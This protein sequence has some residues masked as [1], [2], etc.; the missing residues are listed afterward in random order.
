MKN[1]YF[2]SCSFG[3]DSTATAILAIEKGE[4][5][6][7]LVYC[8]IMFDKEKSAE[9]PEHRDFIYNT[10][11]PY[12]EQRGVKTIVLRA[13]KT[14]RE[15]MEA[16]VTKGPRKGKKHGFPLSGKKGWCSIKR[17]C[18]LPP[19][20]KFQK[21]HPGAVYYEGICIDEKSRIKE[22]KLAQGRYLLVK[23]GYTQEMARNLCKVPSNGGPLCASMT[24]CIQAK[25]LTS[26]RK[27]CTCRRTQY[28]AGPDMTIYR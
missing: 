17:D 11:I 4:P 22:E 24:G 6:S 1:E 28:A 26:R 7:A 16:R 25:S 21:E 15:W 18:K 2:V 19:L 13:E 10:A 8:E 5:L 12:F 14:A 20:N 23:Y 27:T 9:V 3:A